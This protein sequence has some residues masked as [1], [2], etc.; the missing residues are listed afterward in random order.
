M[1]VWGG[2]GSHHDNIA[3]RMHVLFFFILLLF[4]R[5]VFDKINAM[6]AILGITLARRFGTKRKEAFLCDLARDASQRIAMHLNKVQVAGD[7]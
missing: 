5:A 4:V 1:C 3:L 6:S 7:P 2:G